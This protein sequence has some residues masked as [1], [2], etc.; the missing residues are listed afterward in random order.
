MSEVE[1][2]YI[3]RRANCQYVCMHV[4]EAA[5]PG[6]GYDGDSKQISIVLGSSTAI[7][8]AYEIAFVEFVVCKFTHKIT[9]RSSIACKFTHKMFLG[10]PT[11][12]KFTYGLVL[13]SPIS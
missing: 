7:K 1:L 5:R 8:F 2:V 10:A 3:V 9:V 6:L 11:V 12:R 13:E 4:W